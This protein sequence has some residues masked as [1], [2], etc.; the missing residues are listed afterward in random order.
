MIEGGVAFVSEE[1]LV[2]LTGQ[3]PA[4]IS[5]EAEREYLSPMSDTVAYEQVIN[6]PNTYQVKPYLSAEEFKTYLAGA[7]LA[8]NHQENEIVVCNPAKNHSWIFNITTASWYKYTRRWDSFFPVYP[9]WMGYVYEDTTWY[10]EDLSQENEGIEEAIMIHAETRPFKFNSPANPKALKRIQLLGRV[11]NAPE[12]PFGIHLFGSNDG[13]EYFLQAASSFLNPGEDLAIGRSTF[14]CKYFIF[15][16][17]GYV[18]D[19]SHLAALA[20]DVEH[21]YT[22]KLR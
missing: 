18:L 9:K 8:Y 14:S 6:N 19:T 20:A 10:M 21:R 16:F 3:R 4:E 1:G 2:I 5:Q 22:N 12:S 17:G 11:D 13:K 15:I 7:I